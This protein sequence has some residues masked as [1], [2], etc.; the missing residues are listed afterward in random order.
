MGYIYQFDKRNGKTYVYEKTKKTNPKTGE[1]VDARKIIGRLDKET[2]TI[3][4]TGKKGPKPKTNTQSK[5]SGSIITD[6]SSLYKEVNI[7]LAIKR[8]ELK[9]LHAKYDHMSAKMNQLENI[10]EEALRILKS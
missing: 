1:I 7:Q 9:A 3:V 6:Y 5:R 8:E 10:L 4:P 2:N